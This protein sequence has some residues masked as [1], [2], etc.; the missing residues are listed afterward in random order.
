MLQQNV[1]Q[2]NG[3][4]K[5]SNSMRHWNGNQLCAIDCETT[6]LDSHWHEILQICILPLDSNIEPRKD[7]I[8]FYI[9]LIPEHL[10]RVNPDALKVNKTKL[11][12]LCK[13][14]HDMEKAKDLLDEWI[15]KLGLP[16]TKGGF[17]KK[18]MPLGQNFAFDKGFIMRWLGLD[19]Y[20]YYFDY[21]Y[22]DTMI[23][24][25]YLNDR[26]AMHA[27]KV[28]FSKIRLA[29][30][31]KCFDIDHKNAHNALQDC[32]VT[33]KVYKKMLLEGLL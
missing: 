5:M 24:A 32:I 23:A 12:E 22:K 11:S 28:P 19:T 10:E 3:R 29:W 26:A 21:H 15:N 25:N 30:L 13:S 2:E 18:I 20:D 9:N 8:P 6:G 16:F 1:R 4:E 7:I 17:R 31:A 33:A 14:G 27:E